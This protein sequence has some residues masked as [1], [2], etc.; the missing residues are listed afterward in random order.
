MESLNIGR[1]HI[2][3]PY[4]GREGEGAEVLLLLSLVCAILE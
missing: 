1:K 2:S 4:S 3:R